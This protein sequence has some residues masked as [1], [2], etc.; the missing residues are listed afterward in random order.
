MSTILQI[1]SSE[2]GN[3][4][5]NT[6]AGK[7]GV[8]RIYAQQNDKPIPVGRLLGTDSS[9]TLYLGK[10]D[11]FTDR[12]IELK[13]STDPDY[14]SAG[15]EFGVRYK[16]NESIRIAYPYEALYAELIQSENPREL[17]KEKLM[18]YFNRFGELPPFN[19][20]G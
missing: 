16:S 18:G 2:F 4:I 13:K 10:A 15:H 11:Y 8:Y 9:G 3:T 5:H 20:V 17:E 6:L 1:S 14:T 12:T 19:R 7:G